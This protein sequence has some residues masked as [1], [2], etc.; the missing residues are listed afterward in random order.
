M[1]QNMT[2][3]SQSDEVETH[4]RPMVTYAIIKKLL[5][6]PEKLHIL[7][8]KIKGFYLPFVVTIDANN[9][10]TGH[11]VICSDGHVIACENRDELIQAIRES[12]GPSVA[13]YYPGMQ[14]LPIDE[15]PAFQKTATGPTLH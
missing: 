6:Q 9:E 11:G 13:I 8:H 1:T 4:G 14:P 7:I 10:S 2:T 12:L 3:Q 5:T 15:E